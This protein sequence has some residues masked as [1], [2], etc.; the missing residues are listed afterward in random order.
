MLADR[1]FTLPQLASLV[2]IEYRTLHTWVCR[3]LLTA[4]CQRAKGSG[5]RN[6]FDGADALEAYV[7]AD[8][9]R[10][11][12]ELSKLEAVAE[13][14]R[15]SRQDRGRQNVLLVSGR[16][17]VSSRDDL[18]DGVAEMSPTLVYDL[19]HGSTALQRRLVG[20]AE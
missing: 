3:G 14:L 8:L 12:V 5:T 19:A 9:R 17:S 4:S 15:D 7:L 18:A 11:G 6:L 1:T 13:Q 10:A 2:G 20:R 16:V